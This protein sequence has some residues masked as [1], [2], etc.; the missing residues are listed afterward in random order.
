M[1]GKVARVSDGG[2]GKRPR[3]KSVAENAAGKFVAAGHRNHHARRMRYPEAYAL[4][5]TLAVRSSL[6][7]LTQAPLMARRIAFH[8]Q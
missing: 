1:E 6:P 8:T 2:D 3:F 5:G 4:T 7:Q